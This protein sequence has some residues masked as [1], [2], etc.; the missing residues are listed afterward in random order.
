MT[1]LKNGLTVTRKSYVPPVWKLTNN[2]AFRY[3]NFKVKHTLILEQFGKKQEVVFSTPMHVK[4]NTAI[5]KEKF[6]KF[7]FY[8]N[9]FYNKHQ[10]ERHIF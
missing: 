4:A 7:S 10:Y 5:G 2:F 1:M 8:T 9:R 6:S 3:I